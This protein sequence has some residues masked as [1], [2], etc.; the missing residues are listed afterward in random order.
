[1]ANDWECM[2]RFN[3]YSS[4]F[5]KKCMP[6]KKTENL[7]LAEES[8]VPETLATPILWPSTYSI[9]PTRPSPCSCLWSLQ[10]IVMDVTDSSVHS[11][12]SSALMKDLN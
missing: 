10:V 3:K 1:M 4:Q 12:V 6:S 2:K 9:G 11:S 7:M 5:L 8:N